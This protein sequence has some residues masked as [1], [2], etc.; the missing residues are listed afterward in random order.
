MYEDK[1][2]RFSALVA[3]ADKAPAARQGHERP[4]LRPARRPR[5]LPAGAAGAPR[6]PDLG[7][8]AG[9]CGVD[10]AQISRLA[11]ELTE[12]GLIEGPGREVQRRYRGRLRLTD[13]AAP[14]PQP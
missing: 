4:L 13:E 10:R 11:S 3:R 7:E 9:A 6:R 2:R 5:L 12:H 8:L 1:F 14:P